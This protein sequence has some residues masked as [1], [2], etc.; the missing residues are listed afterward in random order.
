V[1]VTN[2]TKDTLD[3]FVTNNDIGL[4]D[5]CSWLPCDEGA[6]RYATRTRHPHWL[7]LL[8]GLCHARSVNGSDISV[9]DDLLDGADVGIRP[10]SCVR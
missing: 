4:I 10:S 6:A 5:F 3:D 9:F 8:G 2:L 1:T 7:S